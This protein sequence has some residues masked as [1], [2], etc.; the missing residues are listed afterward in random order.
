MKTILAAVLIVAVLATHP[1][2]KKLVSEINSANLSWKAKAP[3]NNPLAHLSVEEIKQM[4]GTHIVPTPEVLSTFSESQ[5]LEATPK[6]WDW[7][8]DKKAEYSDGCAFAVRDQ[9]KCG[10]CWAFGAAGALS[11]RFCLEGDKT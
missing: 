1:I 6:N 2:N 4:L 3:E 8:S 11:H 10:S 5:N 9:G 7:R